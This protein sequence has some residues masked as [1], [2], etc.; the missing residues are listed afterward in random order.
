MTTFFHWFSFIHVKFQLLIIKSNSFDSIIIKPCFPYHFHVFKVYSHTKHHKDSLTLRSVP[1]HRTDLIK[2]QT[3][4]D[5][6]T[7]M[8]GVFVA[9]H[10]FYN[11]F[12]SE[13]DILKP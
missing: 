8:H 5:E 4:K 3:L 12:L 13:I 6:I 1:S 11:A 7:H 9:V 10:K 2:S